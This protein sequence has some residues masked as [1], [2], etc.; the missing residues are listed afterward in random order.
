MNVLPG[1]NDHF[2]NAHAAVSG[3]AAWR[4][5]PAPGPTAIVPPPKVVRPVAPLSVKR[6]VGVYGVL[7]L[8]AGQ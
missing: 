8:P 5:L 1:M 3:A 6:R 4:G 2:K 7:L